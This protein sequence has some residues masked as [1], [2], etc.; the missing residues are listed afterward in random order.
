MFNNSR[1]FSKSFS[2]R[3]QW[4]ERNAGKKLS[5]VRV[6]V[7]CLATE[8]QG[9]NE[10]RFH[11]DAR[12]H[13]RKLKLTSARL[14]ELIMEFGSLKWIGEVMEGVWLGDL[15]CNQLPKLIMLTWLWIK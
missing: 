3:R 12:L 4:T 14:R 11:S 13:I 9:G 6:S 8:V 15:S 1:E 10:V 2:N 7:R 5:S